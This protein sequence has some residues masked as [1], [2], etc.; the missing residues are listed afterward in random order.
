LQYYVKHGKFDVMLD[1]LQCQLCGLEFELSKVK[2]AHVVGKDMTVE[3]WAKEFPGIAVEEQ[4]GPQNAILL[5]DRIELAW[6]K[7]FFV[8]LPITSSIMLE[9]A[10]RKWRCQLL[11]PEDDLNTRLIHFKQGDLFLRD[12]QDKELSFAGETAGPRTRFMCYRSRLILNMWESRL[13]STMS[14]TQRDQLQEFRGILQLSSPSGSLRG[15]SDVP[16]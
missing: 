6:E 15:G 9:T 14:A 4:M 7:G 10:A 1:V 2:A 13:G 11:C 5:L 16:S 3:Q 8:F 12:L